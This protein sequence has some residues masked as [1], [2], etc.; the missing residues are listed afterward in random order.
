LTNNDGIFEVRGITAN[1]N[2]GSYQLSMDVDYTDADGTRYVGKHSVP[3]TNLGF[4]LK[5]FLIGVAAAG[6]AI[7][8]VAGT[9]TN[10]D[11]SRVSLGPG[12]VGPQ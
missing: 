7:G 11:P 8:V 1:S 9:A 2:K 12:R 6:V 4:A 10:G 3:V 5:P